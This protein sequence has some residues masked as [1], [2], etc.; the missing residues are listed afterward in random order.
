MNSGRLDRSIKVW[1]GYFIFLL[2]IILPTADFLQ[3][4]NANSG[5]RMTVRVD[6][7]VYQPSGQGNATIQIDSAAEGSVLKSWLEHGLSGRTDLP[8]VPVSGSSATSMTIPF[9]IPPGVWGCTFH[10]ELHQGSQR[11]AGATDVFAVGTNPFR[12]GQ[13]Q[14]GGTSDLTEAAAQ[15]L[16]GVNAYWPD[17]WRRTKGTWLEIYCAQP[18]EVVG[19][20]TDWDQW[21]SMQDRYLRSK[22]AI[23]A[24]TGSAHELGM[25]VMMYNN[26]TPSGWVGADWARKHPEWLAYNYTGG[27]LGH[28]AKLYVEDQEKMKTWHKTMDAGERPK[29]RWRGFQPFIL[30]FGADPALIDFACDQML[31]ARADLSYDGVRFDGHWSVGQF[32]T[33]L[34]YDILGRRLNHG[35]SLDQ[36][37]KQILEQTKTYIA[38]RKPDFYYGYN[39]GLNYEYAAV[40]EPE[41]FR[42]ACSGGGMILFEGA[43]FDGAHSDWRIG[44]KA[45]RDA[46]L[47]VHQYG[48]TLYGQARMLHAAEMFPLNDFSVRYCLIVNFAATSHIYGGAYPDHGSYSPLLENYYHFALRY[49]EILYD[50]NLR[51]I[52]DPA[53]QMDVKVNGS[54]HPDLWWKLYTYKR[55]MDGKYQ[56]ITHLINMPAPGL[57]KEA[58]TID[59]QPPPIKDV[60]VSFARQPERVYILD[61][62][63]DPWMQ[64]QTAGSSLV[65]PEVKSWK[66][67]VQEFSGSCDDIPAEIFPEDS[68]DGKDI[69]PDPKDGKIVFPISSFARGEEGTYLIKDS[70]AM[71][72]N[73]LYCKAR[74]LAE[75]LFI[76][77]G[78]RQEAGAIL[79]PG[80]GRITLRLKVADNQSR[81]AILDLSGPFGDKS[82]PRNTFRKSNAYQAFSFDYEV[83]EGES[84]Y[85][86]VR[87]LGGADLWIDSI[88]IEQTQVA[89]DRDRFSARDLDTSRKPA[90]TA[91]THK[92]HVARGLW[93]DYFGFDAA[94]KEAGIESTSSWEVI[95]SHQA[96]VPDGF[97][98][99][100]DEMLEYDLIAILNLAADELQPENRRNLREYVDRG[101]TLFVGGGTRAFGHGNYQNT[102]L[103]DLLPV[104][105]KQRDLV[106]A[107]GDAQLI[108]VTAGQPITE[109]IVSTSKPREDPFSFATAE[110]VSDSAPRNVY[111]HA[112]T[113]KPRAT[114]LLA[115][116]GN[117]ILTTWKFGKGRVYAMT[118]T[119]LG[120]TAEGDLPWWNWTGWNTL[121]VR[122]LAESSASPD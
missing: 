65:I 64:E 26:A 91:R 83:V 103:A 108:Q 49:G 42:D 55:P 118:G 85:T 101:G 99:T 16:D 79:A 48:G 31:A 81:D 120:E 17:Q 116:D 1:T 67:V 40:K 54:E 11:L 50:E 82:I 8:D 61:P 57:T 4:Q 104:E 90:H 100:V 70:Q 122:I 92:A 35:Q 112:A 12:L 41:T 37:N 53:Q 106:R 24:L 19:L 10:A 69:A 93:Q 114:V 22:K 3:A 96:R 29:E 51:P 56:I 111:Y 44:A 33:T 34:G 52:K 28:A 72:G 97:P 117:P 73:S 107:E 71:L 74:P 66:I 84:G 76:L 6:R 47:R 87:Y 113:A 7:V 78:P 38:E 32:W 98:K 15:K 46:A 13:E 2:G 62:E 60:H 58:S 115:S 59:K 119:P 89:S 20:A 5:L 109:G 36:T 86:T 68:F 9:S 21:I 25:K 105:I 45:M 102:L 18:T 77:D 110:Q 88:V 30:A 14:V 80:R 63:Q 121:L 95:S 27:M 75:P 94:M 23:R 39:Y 43:M